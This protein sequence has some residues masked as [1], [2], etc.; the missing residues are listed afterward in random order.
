MKKIALTALLLL[1]LACPMYGAP[2]TTLEDRLGPV[3]GQEEINGD[4]AKLYRTKMATIAELNSDIEGLRVFGIQP[5][6]DME[7]KQGSG[8]VS[9]IFGEELGAAKETKTKI[10]QIEKVK[11]KMIMVLHENGGVVYTLDA[12]T[13]A[14]K[15]ITVLLKAPKIIDL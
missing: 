9:L 3:V 10:D 11:V 13:Q 8:I 6:Y 2:A 15:F 7:Q 14:L 1:S 12:K 5:D 4:I